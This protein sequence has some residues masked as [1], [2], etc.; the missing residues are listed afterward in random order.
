MEP[1]S[2]SNAV[3]WL[4]SD[5]APCSTVEGLLDVLREKSF[6]MEMHMVDLRQL[7][8]SKETKELVDMLKAKL[9]GRIVYQLCLPGWLD[10]HAVGASWFSDI[11]VRCLFWPAMF[12]QPNYP[13]LASQIVAACKPWLLT[14]VVPNGVEQHTWEG[15]RLIKPD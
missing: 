15:V 12:Y 7:Q 11:C 3:N 2:A 14:L 4:P 9:A 6:P 5:F 8:P 10:V 13:D 1:C